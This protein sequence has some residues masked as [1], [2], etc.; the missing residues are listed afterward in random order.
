MRWFFRAPKTYV[1][2]NGSENDYNCML[3]FFVYLIY[4]EYGVIFKEDFNMEMY[5]IGC[6]IVFKH[7]IGNSWV[8][9]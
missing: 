6:H 9:M 3:K 5:Y 1:N 4:V 8:I 2:N 7:S